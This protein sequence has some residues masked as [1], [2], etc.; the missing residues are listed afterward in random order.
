[1][2]EQRILKATQVDGA[3]SDR[4]FAGSCVDPKFSE[5]DH[6]RRSRNVSAQNRSNTGQ[7]LGIRERGAE[8]VIGSRLEGPQNIG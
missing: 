5:L 7:Q 2:Y 3:R 1:M 6:A 4:D 8:H